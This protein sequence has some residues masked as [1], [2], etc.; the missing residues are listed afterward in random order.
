MLTVE[1]FGMPRQCT[2][3]A[4]TAVGGET[5]VAILAELEAAYPALTGLRRSDGGL[6]PHYL[7]SLD[8]VRFLTDPDERLDPGSRLLL[9]SADAGG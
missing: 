4:Q 6:S 9:L 8:G 7:L 5:V 1:F 3:C 2:G